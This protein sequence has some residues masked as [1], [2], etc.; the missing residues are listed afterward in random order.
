MSAGAATFEFPID[1]VYQTLRVKSV[2]LYLKEAR[3]RF[4]GKPIPREDFIYEL[5]SRD[6]SKQG[7][8][9]IADQ[10]PRPE[11]RKHWTRW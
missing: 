7:Y 4:G 10:T 1:A 5:M 2:D 9:L 3:S 6:R 11:D 8:A